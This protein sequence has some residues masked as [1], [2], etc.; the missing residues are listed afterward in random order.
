MD[1]GEFGKRRFCTKTHNF[2]LTM[3][4]KHTRPENSQKNRVVRD[5]RHCSFYKISWDNL[6]QCVCCE[7]HQHESMN[8][9]CSIWLCGNHRDK[10]I[11]V[12]RAH[13]TLLV[14]LECKVFVA[15]VFLIARPAAHYIGVDHPIKC[16][17]FFLWKEEATKLFWRA[18]Y[19]LHFYD[20]LVYNLCTYSRL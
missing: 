19:P 4:Y 17:F 10:S 5:A 15:K 11:I 7:T 1:P 13:I 20:A 6:W 14:K 8:G 16:F 2:K 12:T 3:T 18:V 9:C